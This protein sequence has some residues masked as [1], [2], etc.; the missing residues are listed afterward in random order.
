MRIVRNDQRRYWGRVNEVAKGESVEFRHT[1]HQDCKPNDVFIINIVSSSY[2]PERDGYH[3]KVPVTNLRTGK[4]SYVDCTR[5]VA[6]V[7]ADVVLDE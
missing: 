1:F 2:R 6:I 7:S 5:E 3:N 4:L